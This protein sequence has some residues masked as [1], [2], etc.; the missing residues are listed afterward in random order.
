M[1]RAFERVRWLR[2]AGP[3]AA[4]PSDDFYA[5]RSISSP[6]TI[7]SGWYSVRSIDRFWYKVPMIRT[8]YYT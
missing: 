2:P 8:S 1:L 4:L 7:L 3:T 5:N 6:L